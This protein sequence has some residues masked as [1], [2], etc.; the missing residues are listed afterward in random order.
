MQTVATGW[1]TGDARLAASAFAPDAV[2][3]EPPERQRHVGRDALYALSGGEDPPPMSMTWHHLL[4]DAG[5]G[6]GAGEYTFVIDNA[7]T[8]HGVTMVQVHDGLI[9]RWR[10]YQYR[11]DG[12]NWEEFVGDTRFSAPGTPA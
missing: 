8:Y 6:I 2:Y 10:E 4:Y 9:V 12:V 5:R 1:S 11:E 3:I 7:R